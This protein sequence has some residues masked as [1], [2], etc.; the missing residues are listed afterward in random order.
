MPRHGRYA[1][2]L[3]NGMLASIPSHYDTP[4]SLY[5]TIL[6]SIS[7]IAV[8]ATHQGTPASL[9]CAT[10]NPNMH[11]ESQVVLGPEWTTTEPMSMLKAVVVV[12]RSRR[13]QAAAIPAPSIATNLTN[14]LTSETMDTSSH[15]L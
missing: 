5:S 12:R 10:A 3:S 6:S 15:I 8:Q 11:S 2:P 13:Q 1:C 9:C 7:C 14:P 4:N